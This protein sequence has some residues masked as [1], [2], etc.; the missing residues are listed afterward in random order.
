MTA[1]VSSA[2]GETPSLVEISTEAVLIMILQFQQTV[3][4]KAA[5]FGFNTGKQRNI[6]GFKMP[7]FPCTF[8]NCHLSSH[9]C[10]LGL[11]KRRNGGDGESQGKGG[12]EGLYKE[13]AALDGNWLRL[14]P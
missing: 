11:G 2:S 1:E 14:A 6:V 8:S 13:E 5:Q 9:L 12:N 4:L 10:G 7:G 3:F